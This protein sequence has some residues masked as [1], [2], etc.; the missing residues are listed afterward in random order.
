MFKSC[1]P[2]INFNGT[3]SRELLN[4]KNTAI[5]ALHALMTAMGNATPHG[6]DFQ[7]VEPIKYT[8]ARHEHERRTNA[9]SALY[10]ALEAEAMAIMEHQNMLHSKYRKQ[11]M[12]QGS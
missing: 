7:T 4:Q 9:L 11:Q 2:V 10:E 6:R 1:P 12:E 3:S 8:A 5:Q